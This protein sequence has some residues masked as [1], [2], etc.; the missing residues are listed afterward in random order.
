MMKQHLL[1]NEN[2]VQKKELNLDVKKEALKKPIVKIVKKKKFM[3]VAEKKARFEE[4]M[5]FPTIK[6]YNELME[7]YIKIAND[8][9]NQTNLEE[10]KKL[11]K[12]YKV[13]TD[14][15]LLLA[16]KPHPVSIVLAQA[17]MESGWG[18][19]RFF[20]EANNPFGIWS[21]NKH[22]PRIPAGQ[23]RDGKVIWLKK[24]SSIEDAVR[25][26]YKNLGRSPFFRDFREFR[27]VS[28][29]PY[30]LV[31]KLNRYSEK[32]DEYGEILQSVIRHNNFERFDVNQTTLL[33]NVSK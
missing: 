11:K 29:N 26:Y 21:F 3:S 10:I 19:S 4:L 23:T 8:I 27:S 5:V 7:R 33:Y 15:E 14:E 31:T 17:A 16:L 24:Y 32:G 25:D 22:E 12:E 13:K 28:N 18:T 2:S 30:E 6:V 20:K 1:K 9:Q